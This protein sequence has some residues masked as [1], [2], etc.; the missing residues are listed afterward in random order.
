MSIQYHQALIA[1]HRAALIAPIASFEAEV[2][3]QCADDPSQF[4]LRQ[5]ESICV[6]SARAIARL[7]LEL[8]DRKTNSRVLN[9][10]PSLLACVVIAISLLK[11]SSS[12]LQAADLEVWVFLSW[13]DV[14]SRL[15]DLTA[16]QS[17][18]RLNF[19]AIS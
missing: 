6:N 3:T 9:A 12:R 17:L 5:G 1:L 2:A 8:A 7:V 4:R 13:L 15:I 14:H 19:R 10:G 11:N 18:C 16:S